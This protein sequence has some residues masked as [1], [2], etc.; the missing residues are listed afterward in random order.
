[1]ERRLRR[2]AVAPR[3]LSA[4][5][6]DRGLEGLRLAGPG[7]RALVLRLDVLRR[8]VPGPPLGHRRDARSPLLRRHRAGDA[9]RSVDDLQLAPQPVDA[10]ARV[11]TGPLPARVALSMDDP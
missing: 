6:P 5:D 7:A 9:A 2:R 1:G 3:G 11:V 4:L 8:R 10:V